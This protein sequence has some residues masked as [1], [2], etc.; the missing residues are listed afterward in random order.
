MTLRAVPA[1]SEAGDSTPGG[2]VPRSRE[3]LGGAAVLALGTGVPILLLAVPWLIHEAGLY[4]TAAS[5]AL[6]GFAVSFPWLAR[7]LGAPATVRFA[8]WVAFFGIGLAVVSVVTG[9]QNGLT[10]EPYTTPRYVGLLLQGHNPY[11]T[12]LVVDYVQYGASYHSTSYYVYLPL[13]QFAIVPGLD[14]RWVALAAWGGTLYL[15]R[16]DAFRLLLLGQPY[17]AL[18]AASGY[19]DPVVL[20]LL[21][22][23]FVGYAGRRQRWAELLSLGMKQ[24]AAAIV[25]PYY[26]LRRD[27][28]RA[29]T[30]V[31]VTAAFLLP[32]LLWSPLPT[33]CNAVLYGV[34]A[35]CAPFSNHDEPGWNWN[36]SVY[37]VWVLA[38]FRAEI[39]AAWL[40]LRDR[41]VR[42]LRASRSG[43]VAERFARYAVVGATGVAVNLLLFDL[44][45]GLVAGPLGPFAA[46]ALAFVG[47][48]LWNFSWNYV[49]T[50][51]GR[52]TRALG[53]HL[54]LYAA[55]QLAAL[56]VN[57]A[58]LA[59]LL[60][61]R[62]AALP[63][64]FLGILAASLLGFA[65][66]LR[67]NFLGAAA[68]GR[69]P[70]PGGHVD[71]GVGW[72]G[73]ATEGRAGPR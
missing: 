34:P 71:P 24:F 46:S 61:L 10:D 31:G 1:S 25:V 52:T 12:P 3:R 30:A 50:F 4:E 36:Y 56:G 35:S 15:V 53:V 11:G 28:A 66:N 47:A 13:L 60:D 42:P 59:G 37:A 2:A 8:R 67:W 18:I 16:D 62:V 26:L 21:T 14:Y 69:A 68:R 27:F 19:N 70:P 17:L 44:A 73:D 29:A 9:F 64:Q 6:L 38:A 63:A 7:A 54:T 55:I 41:F 39:G 43:Q 22:L 48:M 23:G 57:L 65:A 51:A 49:W 58:V 5:L 40:Q 20:L 32:F 45:G 72:V 33:L